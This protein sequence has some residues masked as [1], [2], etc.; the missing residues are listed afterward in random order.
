MDTTLARL[1][2]CQHYLHVLK[3][4]PKSVQK[5]ILEKADKDLVIS[6]CEICINILNGNIEL[7]AQSLASLRKYRNL[8]RGLACVNRPASQSGRGRQQGGGAH[9]SKS[10]QYG[11]VSAA[12]WKRKRRYLVQEGKGAF[13]TALLTSALGGAVGKLV[14]NFV[15]SKLRK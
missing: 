12:D 8:V 6:L 5:A 11:R 10:I 15:Q 7:T 3:S 1:A 13:L 14:G 4:S 2:K 9:R